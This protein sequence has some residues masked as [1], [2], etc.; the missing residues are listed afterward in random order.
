MGLLPLFAWQLRR[1]YG[2]SLGPT[3]ALL[4]VWP[5]CMSWETKMLVGYYVWSASFAIALLAVPIGKWT[6]AGMAA[7]V[8]LFAILAR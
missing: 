2:R 5:W 1:G 6:L 7:Q 4:A 3:I 8:A